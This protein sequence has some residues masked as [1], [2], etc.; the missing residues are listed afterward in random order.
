MSGAIVF[1]YRLFCRGSHGDHPATARFLQ[2]GQ[3]HLCGTAGSTQRCPVYKIGWGVK[4]QEDYVNL[5]DV[6]RVGPIW[7]VI[8][9]G[10]QT[11]KSPPLPFPLFVLLFFVA[12]CYFRV[13]PDPRRSS[14]QVT[15]TL[16]ATNNDR[17]TSI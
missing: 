16:V 3:N 17:S 13:G 5:P 1:G 4:D 2:M 15:A 14:V 12:S 8:G 6:E 7:S 10:P 11:M 9:L